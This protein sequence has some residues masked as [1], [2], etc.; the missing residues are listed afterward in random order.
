MHNCRHRWLAAEVGQSPC[1]FASRG[2]VEAIV[3]STA[4]RGGKPE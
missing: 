4:V 2:E 3:R 1:A